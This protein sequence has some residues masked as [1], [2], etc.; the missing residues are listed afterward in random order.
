MSAHECRKINNQIGNHHLLRAGESFA[1]TLKYSVYT[2]L[3]LAFAGVS[4]YAG[5]RMISDTLGDDPVSFSTIENNKY[6]LFAEASGVGVLMVTAGSAAVAFAQSARGKMKQSCL[7]LRMA[8]QAFRAAN[9][10]GNDG[11]R[12]V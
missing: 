9:V 12:S 3:A 1:T 10:C 8:R 4:G 5:Y 6:T 7:E 2:A 11:P